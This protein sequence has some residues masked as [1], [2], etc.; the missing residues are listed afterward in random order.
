MLKP[1]RGARKYENIY[2]L[3]LNLIKIELKT[4]I[5]QNCSKLLKKPRSL[6]SRR[7]KCCLGCNNNA[8]VIGEPMGEPHR[9][10]DMCQR[11]SRHNVDTRQLWLCMHKVF[12]CSLACEDFTFRASPC[13]STKKDRRQKESRG[14][15][16]HLVEV[17]RAEKTVKS[18]HVAA[19]AAAAA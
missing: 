14:T 11:R 6:R 9:H 2:I 7:L 16:D 10:A 8:N 12:N 5:A 18:L 19:A 15:L 13:T 3:I 4:V 17:S 1:P